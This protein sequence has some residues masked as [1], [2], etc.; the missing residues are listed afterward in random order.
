MDDHVEFARMD[1]GESC[2]CSACLQKEAERVEQRRLEHEA[3]IAAMPPTHIV[4]VSLQAEAWADLKNDQMTIPQFI[5]LLK[6][7]GW[8]ILEVDEVGRRVKV[9]NTT[10]PI[11]SG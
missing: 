2:G 10:Q 11:K 9:L 7:N 6:K 3:R 4:A 8:S 5:E 1:D